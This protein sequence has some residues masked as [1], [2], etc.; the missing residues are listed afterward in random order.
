MNSQLIHHRKEKIKTNLLNKSIKK[1]T[2]K[3]FYLKSLT[4]ANRL[5][6]YNQVCSKDVQQVLYCHILQS[7]DIDLKII[8]CLVKTSSTRALIKSIFFSTFSMPGGG[9]AD[10]RSKENFQ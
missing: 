6:K 4:G 10:D 9:L 1:F 2:T 8:H 3:T 5:L 7:T